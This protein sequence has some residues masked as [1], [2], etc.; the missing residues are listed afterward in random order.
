MNIED[1]FEKR[2]EL[3]GTISTFPNQR[4]VTIVPSFR[5]SLNNGVARY[6]FSCFD[7]ETLDLLLT[8]PRSIIYDDGGE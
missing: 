4:T 3:N 1:L 7:K 6:D 2:A 5:K 8:D